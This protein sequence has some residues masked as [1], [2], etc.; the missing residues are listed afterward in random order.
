MLSS[1]HPHIVHMIK[2]IVLLNLKILQ[3]SQGDQDN[4][5]KSNKQNQ[6]F[7][8]HSGDKRVIFKVV[9]NNNQPANFVISILKK[10]SLEN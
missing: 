9:K 7:Q 8:Q 4:S 5:V 6:A 1:V 2:H 10:T 3:S